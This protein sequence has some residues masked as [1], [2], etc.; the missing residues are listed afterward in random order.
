MVLLFGIF[1]SLFVSLFKGRLNV[2]KM[3]WENWNFY[4]KEFSNSIFS[5]FFP[6][7]N[8]PYP[9]T[10]IGGFHVIHIKNRKIHTHTYT[11]FF[12]NLDILKLGVELGRGC[13]NGGL[14]SHVN[15]EHVL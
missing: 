4:C 3:G 10:I 8:Q 9:K 13:G 5:T 6:H 15:K 14:I 1:I 11:L 12:F 7:A 2:K